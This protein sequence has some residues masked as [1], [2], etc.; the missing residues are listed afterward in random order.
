MTATK[1]M[2][3]MTALALMAA[4]TTST[5][6]P[7]RTGTG[8]LTGAAV[9]GLLGSMVGDRGDAAIG[10]GIGAIAGGMIGAHM[11]R[12]AAELQA[13]LGSNAQVVN[14]G[15]EIVV[16]MSQ[17]ILFATDSSAVRPDLQANLRAVAQNINSYPLSMLFVTG[18]TDSTG[19]DAYNQ[20][21]SLRRADAVA[22]VLISAGVPAQRVQTRGMGESQ[23]VASNETAA[24]RA[25]NRRVVLTIRP[26]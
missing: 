2:A 22:G 24:G 11:D 23:P 6:D 16:T 7:Y 25:Q 15:Q 5:G 26:N 18:H 14:T 13:S 20:T 1:A 4:C 3:A 12:Q 17:D 10:A 21:L 8:A 19:S 9:G